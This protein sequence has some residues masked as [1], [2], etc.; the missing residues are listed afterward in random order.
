[1]EGV[2]RLQRGVVQRPVVRVV[3]ALI[4]SRP[5]VALPASRGA[6]ANIAIIQSNFATARSIQS[7][8]LSAS[9]SGKPVVA[10]RCQPHC[11]RGHG[12]ERNSLLNRRW[13]NRGLARAA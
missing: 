10:T 2:I 12:S 11:A 9:T 6:A 13:S 8:I 4:G 7:V 3:R 1:M 5:V